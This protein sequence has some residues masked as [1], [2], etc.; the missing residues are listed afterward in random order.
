MGPRFCLFQILFILSSLGPVADALLEKD[1]TIPVEMRCDEQGAERGTWQACT[2]WPLCYG[3][4]S[5]KN[6]KSLTDQGGSCTH[7][8]GCLLTIECRGAAKYEVIWES[9]SVTPTGGIQPFTKCLDPRKVKQGDQYYHMVSHPL[10]N[11]IC[12]GW[13]C[14]VLEENGR[15]TYDASLSSTGSRNS[16]C[17]Y[18]KDLSDGVDFTI[19]GYASN[20]EDAKQITNV[21]ESPYESQIQSPYHFDGESSDNS[22]SEYINP[23]HMGATAPQ[24]ST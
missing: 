15:Y 5:T 14:N 9:R 23:T 20:D 21:N 7:C 13:H 10:R 3:H 4:Y 8:P 6:M 17:I 16:L 19:R 22:R 2:K 12:N 11:N 1:C 24:R 18:V